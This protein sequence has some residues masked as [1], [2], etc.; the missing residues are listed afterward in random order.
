M[1][2]STSQLELLVGLAAILSLA[3]ATLQAFLLLRED[4]GTEEMRSIAQA[5]RD[6]IARNPNEVVKKEPHIASRQLALIPNPADQN[7]CA[8]LRRPVDMIVHG[9]STSLFQ[10]KQQ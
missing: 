8:Q 5:I 4:E 10:A 1:E 3:Y 2:L 6:I 7:R 9:W